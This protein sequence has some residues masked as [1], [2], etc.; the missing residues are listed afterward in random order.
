[1]AHPTT[2]HGHPAAAQAHSPGVLRQGEPRGVPP[3]ERAEP[4]LFDDIDPVL[5][6]RL[7]P[8]DI[9]TAEARATALAQGVATAE[10]GDELEASRIE[11][12]P[13]ATPLQKK[14]A[15]VANAQ[16]AVKA[17]EHGTPEQKEA[18]AAEL[19]RAQAMPELETR[20]AAMSGNQTTAQKKNEAIAKAQQAVKD[21]EHGTQEQKDAAAAALKRAQSLPD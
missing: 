10:A 16:A 17:A 7:Y 18:A 13:A 21:A 15:A 14:Q 19:K 11:F 12:D 9:N 6:V 8:D 1:M 5:L 3:I 4:V 2:N 20:R